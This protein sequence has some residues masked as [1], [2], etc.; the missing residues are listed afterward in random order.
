M[1][2]WFAV[3]IPAL[4]AVCIVT[5]PMW[6]VTLD[7][8]SLEISYLDLEQGVAEAA[9]PCWGNTIYGARDC[10]GRALRIT[11]AVILVTLLPIVTHRS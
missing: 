8:A 3:H 6:R 5:M 10:T 1:D 2:S 11:V 9:R 4:R 7:I